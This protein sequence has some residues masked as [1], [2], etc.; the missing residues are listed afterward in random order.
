METKKKSQEEKCE[1]ESAMPQNYGGL[2][3]PKLNAEEESDDAA[4]EL[5]GSTR[6]REN[7]RELEKMMRNWNVHGQREKT[8]AFELPK[9]DN[10]NTSAQLL[11]EKT[12]RTTRP[13]SSTKTKILPLLLLSSCT[14][15]S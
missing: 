10:N 15:P 2:L 7:D 12:Q 14:L 9:H 8:G 1:E 4:E 13:S 6:A 3:R 5:L 11:A